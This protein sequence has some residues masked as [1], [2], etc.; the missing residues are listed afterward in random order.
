MERQ[1]STA[2]DVVANLCPK[3]GLC[4]NGVLFGDVELQASDDAKQLRALGLTLERE[5]KALRFSQPCS[6][7]DGAL[8]KIYEQRPARCRRFE[9]GLVRS[10]AAGSKTTQAA[11]KAIG[12]CRKQVASVRELLE[13]LGQR[14][15]HLPLSR[16]CA[17]VI[18]QPIDLSASEEEIEMRGELLLAIARLTSVLDRDFLKGFGT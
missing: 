11:V 9:C 13:K 7:F 10:V 3:C 6:C 18:S 12:Q 15:E 4:C 14:D 8:C 16:R 1:Q 2:D 17:K 5:G